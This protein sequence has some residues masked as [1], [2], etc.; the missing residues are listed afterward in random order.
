MS[1]CWICHSYIVSSQ[2]RNLTRD[3]LYCL[4]LMAGDWLDGCAVL[5]G[6]GLKDK[7]KWLINDMKSN[8]LLDF[9]NLKHLKGCVYQILNH[10]LM[11]ICW[12]SHSYNVFCLF[13][14][15]SLIRSDKGP[16]VLLGGWWLVG[17]LCS[18]NW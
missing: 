12:I 5:I 9:I 2:I 18:T 16:T 13:V 3:H 6:K 1:I 17:W 11:Y 15:S 4:N 7:N 14:F 8:L 10:S